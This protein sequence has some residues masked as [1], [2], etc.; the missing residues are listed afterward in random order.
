MPTLLYRDERLVAVDKPSGLL[1]HRSPIDR[2]EKR[3]ALQEVRNLIGERVYPVHRLDKPT[4]GV[5]LF[6]LDASM[7]ATLSKMF[8]HSEVEKRYV[9]VVRGYCE[10]EGIVDHPLKQMLDTKAQ[11]IQGITK[12]VQDA[13]TYYRTLAKVE[14]PFCVDKYPTT[15]Y[16][17]V[18]LLPK[19]GRKHQL[20]RHMKHI[21]HP[22]IG[23][24]KHGRGEHNRFFRNQF[25]I[26]RLLLHA[27]SL[28]FIHPA[29]GK[30]LD[31]TAP[32][33]GEFGQLVEKLGWNGVELEVRN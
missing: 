22:I 21:Y 18:S 1:V 24:T 29:S 30:K 32:L 13:T 25:G 33:S 6:A 8:R 4:S 23:D 9:A 3:F 17:L 15:R 11:K 14:L 16:S 19:S 5:L 7:A 20:R 26:N 12:E 2:R 28:S 10:D 31:I 27:Y